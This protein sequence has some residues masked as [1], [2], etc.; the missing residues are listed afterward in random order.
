M[1]LFERAKMLQAS[2]ERVSSLITSIND[3]ALNL[4]GCLGVSGLME[5]K[6]DMTCAEGTIGYTMELAHFTALDNEERLEVLL[7]FLEETLVGSPKGAAK[8]A[9]KE[10]EPDEPT[11]LPRFLN[12]A[13][14]PD[15]VA[16]VAR[17]LGMERS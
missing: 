8:A 11:P 7:R 1:N 10:S 5:S 4:T 6:A 16:A 15:E 17:E 2:S 9:F 14:G 3:I 12:R 13:I